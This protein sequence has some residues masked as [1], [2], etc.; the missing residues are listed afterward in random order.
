MKAKEVIEKL[1]GAIEK[2]G[3]DC[4]V[5]LIEGCCFGGD[6]Y[7]IG[8]GLVATNAEALKNYSECTSALPAETIV[9]TKMEILATEYF[10]GESPLW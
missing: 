2:Y 4:E 7:G 10:G 3:D 9:K 5:A 1:Y 6:R 8:V